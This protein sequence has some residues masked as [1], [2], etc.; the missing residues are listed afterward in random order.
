MPRFISPRGMTALEWINAALDLDY[1]GIDFAVNA[2]ND[3]LLFEANATMVMVPLSNDKG[4][5]Q[6]GFRCGLCRPAR[7]AHHQRTDKSA[8]AQCAA[9]RGAPV[10]GD[11][12][13]VEQHDS[14]DQ[15]W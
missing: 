11:A 8:R 7:H 1:G 15:A 4:L 14:R 6:A 2:D 10:A 13:R 3:V 5:P 9:M 12:D